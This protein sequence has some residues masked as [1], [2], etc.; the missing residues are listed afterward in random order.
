M[1]SYLFKN[2][3]F[4]NILK[5]NNFEVSPS[6]L[7]I[8]NYDERP[9]APLDNFYS[10]GLHPWFTSKY[11]QD[12]KYY[13][14]LLNEMASNKKCLLIGETG[15][16]YTKDNIQKQKDYFEDHIKLASTLKKP[17]LIHCVKSQQDILNMRKAHHVSLPWVFHDY[18]G[19]E[20]MIE[21]ISNSGC[22]FS[23]GRN[24]YRDSSKLV[25]NIKSIPIDRVLLETDEMEIDI[26]KCYERFSKLRGIS[27]EELKIQVL[28]NFK[29]LTGLS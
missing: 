4:I 5:H 27:I 20:S 16:D 10:F 22:Y 2:I 18:N 24:L 1:T 15:L 13:L 3:E 28:K 17:L 8:R 7:T 6:S 19:N 21:D 12:S 11:D 9:D 25:K 26:K 23:L 14:S 29:S